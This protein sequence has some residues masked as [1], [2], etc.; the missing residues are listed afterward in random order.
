VLIDNPTAD[1]R[2]RSNATG[3][4]ATFAECVAEHEQLEKNVEIRGARVSR[5]SELASTRVGMQLTKFKHRKL[6]NGV[7]DTRMQMDRCVSFLFPLLPERKNVRRACRRH[8]FLCRAINPLSKA[9]DAVD[10]GRATRDHSF[11]ANVFSQMSVFL[12]G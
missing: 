1:V 8:G 4:K 5:L 12:E 11:S 3:S 6:G 10:I 2:A 7:P 9:A